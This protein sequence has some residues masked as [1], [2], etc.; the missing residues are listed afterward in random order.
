MATK[1]QKREA[2]LAKREAYLAEVKAAGLL[3]QEWDRKR[4]EER[5]AIVDGV[6][7]EIEQHHVDV[8]SKAHSQL[9]MEPTAEDISR[10]A[11]AL[12]IGNGG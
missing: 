2:A 7:A 3:S 4:R 9:M 6:H 8:M 11:Q 1:K 5:R 12:Y 10:L